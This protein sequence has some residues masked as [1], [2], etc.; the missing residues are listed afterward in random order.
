MT[1]PRKSSKQ[2]TKKKPARKPQ[3]RAPSSRKKPTPK[4][5]PQRKRPARAPKSAGRTFWLWRMFGKTTKQRAVFFLSVAMSVFVLAAGAILYVSSTLPDISTLNTIDKK[6]GITFETSDGT[7]L[8]SYGDVYGAHIS[9]EDVPRTLIDAVI[10]TEDRRFF[11]HSGIDVFGIARAMLMNMWHGRVVQGGSTITQ[12]LA[13][14]I[15]LTPERSLMRKAQEALLALWLEG[16][17]SKKEILELYLNRVYLGSGAF[18]I[19][20]AAKRYFDKSVPQLT[21]MESAVL[22]GL[23]KAPSR[24]APTASMER[25][26]ARGKQ[27]LHNMVDAG[28]LDAARIAPAVRNFRLPKEVEAVRESDVRYFTDWIMDQLPE[29]IGRIEEDVIVTTTMDPLLQRVAAEQMAEPFDALAVDKNVTQAALVAMEPDGAVRALMG[30]RKYHESAYNRVTQARRQPGSIFK[31]FV[32]LAGI[33]AGLRPNHIIEDAPLTLIVNGKPWS[34]KNYSGTYEGP[35]SMRDAL[36]DSVNTVAVRISQ[37]A[38]VAA[39][40]DVAARMGL[41]GLL[42]QPSIALGAQE[43]TL[44]Q[45][46]AAYAH[47]PNRGRQLKPYGITKIRTRS[48]LEIY[49][50]QPL[51]AR[52]MLAA[53][54]TEQMHFMLRAVVQE[55]TGR[56]AALQ[57]RDIGGKTGTSQDFKDA[58][59]VGY[60]PKLVTGVWVGNDNNAPMKKVTGGSIP[61]RLWRGFMAEA[62]RGKPISTLPVNSGENENFMP[63][64]FGNSTDRPSGAVPEDQRRVLPWQRDDMPAAPAKRPRKEESSGWFSGDV[65]Y[66]YPE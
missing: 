47:I 38:G 21:L 63:W 51:E 42:P 65:E 43:T 60:T 36:R 41:A 11:E 2:A 56:G 35:M 17:Y 59:F 64:L 22:A 48:G 12:Q 44:M 24:F 6:R 49:R 58:W 16:R 66:K 20:A 9:Y 39:V 30:G 54:T 18:G 46:T 29:Y 45:L 15:F 10:A 14:N 40:V 33:E 23:L 50:H 13:K 5:K 61:A 37:F 26:T 19:D 32:Y 1:P 55:G 31:L 53:A 34:P 57:G 27:V 7:V 62:L 52:R 3:T 25:A 28:M 8:A 4:Q